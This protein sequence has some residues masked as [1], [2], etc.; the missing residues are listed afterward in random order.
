[1]KNIDTHNCEARIL[2]SK[3]DGSLVTQEDLKILA[4]SF[5]ATMV[6]TAYKFNGMSID[7]FTTDED[8]LQL[9]KKHID[10]FKNLYKD[11]Y[12]KLYKYAG[13]FIIDVSISDLFDDNKFN[14]LI[15][16]FYGEYQVNLSDRVI[17]SYNSEITEDDL[18]LLE[19]I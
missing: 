19:G 9:I 8:A 3:K 17:W 1:M 7:C 14:R 12:V 11:C 18:S 6:G 13:D 15:S 10:I 16:D 4:D 2:I 5:Y